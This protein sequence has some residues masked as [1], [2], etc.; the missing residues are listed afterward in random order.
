MIKAPDREICTNSPALDNDEDSTLNE[1]MSVYAPKVFGIVTRLAL[2]LLFNMA[3][4][5]YLLSFTNLL[6]ITHLDIS[7]LRESIPCV[8]IL[9]K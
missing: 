8:L 2:P 5:T 7:L 6:A 3:T 1:I 4:R 9:T